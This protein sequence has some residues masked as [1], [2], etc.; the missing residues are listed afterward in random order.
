MPRPWIWRNIASIQRIMAVLYENTL[1]PRIQ[2]LHEQEEKP[3]GP[4]IIDIANSPIAILERQINIERRRHG[5]EY[6]RRK[7]DDE[8]KRAQDTLDKLKEF[9]NTAYWHE[10]S[11]RAS[12]TKTVLR[13]IGQTAA[14]RLLRIGYLDATIT[15][16]IRLNSAGLERVPSEAWFTELVEGR[17]GSRKRLKIRLPSKLRGK[18]AA[19]AQAASRRSSRREP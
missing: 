1:R 11:L 5:D 7:D 8:Y 3:D 16:H 13:A 19:G 12:S 10:Y 18:R 14:V 17:A 6:K 9:Q 2:A 15:C 4:I